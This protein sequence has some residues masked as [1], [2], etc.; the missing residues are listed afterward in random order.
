MSQV[1]NTARNIFVQELPKVENLIN[2]F[3]F[4]SDF[5]I[6]NLPSE[7]IPTGI[8]PAFDL[9]GLTD[10][11][12]NPN[13]AN[14][15]GTGFDVVVIDTG[16]DQTHPLL[17]D[18]YKFG[19]DYTDFD[20]DPN[21]LQD[22]GTHVSGI[23]GAEDQNIGVAPDVGLIGFKIA[24]G[25]EFNGILV[26]RALQQVLNEVNDPNSD[27]N[28]VAVNLSLG[29]GLY[30][31]ES[32]PTTIVDN[33]RHLLIEELEAAGIVVIAAAGNSYDGE[34]D[35]EGN[36]VD[37]TGNFLNP[38]Q[39]P[40]LS[41]PA[42]YSTIAVGAVWQNNVDTFDTYTSQ[43]IPGVDR[44]AV[45]SQRLDS[46]NFLFAPGVFIPSTVPENT[47]GISS[48][49]SQAAPHVTGAVALLQEIAAGYDVRL[50]PEQLRDYLI[51]NADLVNDGD[52]EQDVVV[53]TNLTYPRINIHQSAIALQNDL[54]NSSL[55]K[56]LFND[57]VNDSEFSVY[58][59]FR[60]DAGVHFYTADVAERDAIL[61][62]LP[63]FNYEGVSY[64]S[65]DPL[66]GAGAIAPVY[67]LLNQ[68]T[69]V[70]LYTI[71]EVEKDT[72]A[73]LSNFTLEGE[74]FYSYTEEVVGSIPIHRFYDQSTGAHFYTPLEAE[75][76]AVETGLP[77]YQY[78]GIAYYALASL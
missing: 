11:R 46:D 24:E 4:D 38:N 26:N 71:S 39:E 31:L 14:I 58:R 72:V 1:L 45:F 15:D 53:N 17:D 34:P 2:D 44:I 29:A 22:H 20:E 70:H 69:G 40:N 28:I 12:N 19:F 18:N 35:S 50:S 77:D 73:N 75:K 64:Q 37:A 61:N 8:N 41:S 27:S 21:D 62:N 30:T 49:T 33:E 16:L 47:I 51:N 42:I 32:Q 67:R 5:N 7:P 68:D 3:I 10:L 63:N 52:D 56:D 78:E 6:Q 59:F 66:T 57:A 36:L 76:E 54:E 9:I 43:Q 55:T 48:G 13:F 60:A 23:I 25:G 65:V 74:A